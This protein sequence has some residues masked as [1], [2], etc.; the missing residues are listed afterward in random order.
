MYAQVEKSKEN[1]SRAVRSAVSQKQ[2]SGESTFQF[3]DNRPEATAQRKQQEVSD[4][5]TARLL[6]P[7]PKQK[8]DT[9][10]PNNIRSTVELLSRRNVADNY[11]TSI[12]Q[13]EVLQRKYEIFFKKRNCIID[14][15]DS[16][17]GYHY[18]VQLL[19]DLAPKELRKHKDKFNEAL[20]AAAKREGI[21]AGAPESYPQ[22]DQPVAEVAD[23]LLAQEEREPTSGMTEGEK[24]IY[25]C[26]LKK[27]R[28]ERGLRYT[29]GLTDVGAARRYKK[30]QTKTLLADSEQLAY[31]KLKQVGRSVGTTGVGVSAGQGAKHGSSAIGIGLGPVAA[32]T[33]GTANTLHTASQGVRVW[34][35]GSGQDEKAEVLRRLAKGH[36]KK[37]VQQGIGTASGTTAG[38][39]TGAAVGSAI[40]VPVL[41]TVVGA[42]VGATVGYLVT[43]I[44]EY[45]G[46]KALQN[47]KEAY[48]DVLTLHEMVLAGDADAL[49]A[50]TTLGVD[51]DTARAKDGWKAL[52]IKI[53]A[54]QE[55]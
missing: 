10:F 52:A 6:K 1:K 45:I 24:N 22:P 46:D 11:N 27:E 26:I 55:I 7:I 15:E 42:G 12:V 16:H 50:F 29:H 44:T 54:H 18:L 3:V 33:A 14:I 19:N 28:I 34:R 38:A 5:C 30:S 9:G 36:M 35:D 49:H 21:T 13:R 32:A 8:N 37:A 2:S 23:V 4:N 20:S 25:A 17:Y 48:Q 41:G 51:E 40:P 43:K 39:F 47:H 53:G 31:F